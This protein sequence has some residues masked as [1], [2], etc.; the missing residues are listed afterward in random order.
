MKM[1]VLSIRTFILLTFSLS[2]YS[3][4]MT[5]TTTSINT[6][7]HD[8]TKLSAVVDYSI[9]G[10]DASE[11]AVKKSAKEIDEITE[12]DYV[13][14][15]SGIG[16]LS[17]ASMLSYYGYSVVVLESHYLPGGVAHTFERDGFHF[18]A[19][20]SLW[21]GMATKPY[22][23]LREILEIIGEADSIEF[24]KYDG[25]VMHIPEGSFKFK[26]GANNFEPIL[27]KFGG[28]NAIAE[29]H[30]LNRVLEPIKFLAGAVPPL[31]LRS[32][33]LFILTILP[34]MLKLITSL[35]SVGKVEGSF[36]AISGKIVKDKFLE[37]WFEF[38]SFALS[39]LPADDT[40]AAAVAYTMRDLHQE[41]ASL[42]YPV[43]GSGAVVNA[44][45]RGVTKKGNKV[46]LNSHVKNILI[47]D[48][49]A[50]G[51]V[52]RRGGKI[53]RAK[54]AVISNASIWDT[55]QLLPEGALPEEVVEKKMSTPMTGS[56]VHLH[57]G[58][59]ATDLPPDLDV[60]YSVINN[61]DPIDAPQNHVIISIPSILDPSLAPPGCHVIHAYAAANEPYELWESLESRADYKQL[62]EDRTQFLWAAIERSIPDVRKRVILDLSATPITHQ[63][64][65]RRYK[66]TYGPALRAGKAKFPYPKTEI[67]GLLCCGDSVFPGIGVPAVAVSGANAAS[68]TV[69]V[70]K[71][72]DMLKKLYEI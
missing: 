68:T 38:L 12:A 39:G 35:P 29:W 16:G 32:D 2:V 64:F 69:S 30:E 3:F 26:V 36:K 52:M 50:A 31:T 15:G 66:G 23:P 63:R 54:R 6:V 18:D 17:A 56:F 24:K 20:P 8:F 58:I 4:R 53:I 48:G 45:I 60:H 13:V 22:N 46:L 37:N 57:I 51:V 47:E 33:P 42:D 67:P 61:W 9:Q 41:G 11:S 21:N 44:L 25:W 65:N 70:W 59:D 19:G 49:K 10:L 28:P 55:T 40:I 5:K 34:H 7:K 43:G 62:K 1:T 72:L 71:Q 27:E 14:I